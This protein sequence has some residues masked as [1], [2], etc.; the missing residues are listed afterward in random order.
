V[1]GVGLSKLIFVEQRTY[2]NDDG[3]MGRFI[4][5]YGSRRSVRRRS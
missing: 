4:D 2:K 5:I 3:N 1:F